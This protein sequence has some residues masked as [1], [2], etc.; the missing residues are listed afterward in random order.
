MKKGKRL[1]SFATALCLVF[2]SMP[3]MLVNAE[4]AADAQPATGTQLYVSPTG[5]DAAEG[6]IGAPLKTL[7]GA[8]NKVR[9]L[10]HSGLPAG[11]ITVNLLGGE[12]LAS[13]A[14]E[15][16]AA[17]SGEAG[18]P[19]VWKAAEGAEVTF[20]GTVSVEPNRFE[21]VTDGGILARLPEAAHDNVYVCDMKA[22]GLDN[23]GPIPK[24]GYGWPEL[25]PPL[26]VVMDGESMHMARYPDKD[27]V[28]PSHI[29][30]SGFNPR[31]NYSPDP[32]KEKGPIWACKDKGLVDMFE[33][34]K[35]EEDVWTYGYFNHTY[36][37]DNVASKTVEMDTQYGVKFTGKH[38]TWYA[39]EGNEPKKFYVYNILCGLDAP[40]EYYLDRTNDKM[41]V[42]SE[43]D[44]ASRKVEL[45]VLADP[46]F[47]LKGA[48]YITIEG[49]HFTAGNANA[50]DLY[51]SNHILIADCL[52][53]N[54]G[55]KGVTMNGSY[56]NHDNTVQSCDFKHMGSGGVL[57]DGGEI[58]SL[59]L[60]NNKVDNCL[61]DDYSVIKRTYAPAVGLFGCGNLVTRNKITNAPHQAVA[62]SGNNH[63]IAG[64]EISHVLYETGDSGAIYTCTR[65]WT[66]RGNVI[67]NN[68]FYD[69]P[70]T[71]HGGTYCIYLDDMASGT[72]ATNNLF[73][74][75]QAHAFLVGGGRDNVITN[76][77]DINNGGWFI[78][79][80]NRCMGWAHKS[81]HIPDGGNYK[82]WKTMFDELNKSENAASLAKWEAQ[83]PGMFDT[84]M[85]T[86]ETCS[87]CSAQRSKGCIPKNA[88]IENNIAVGGA[89]YSFVSEVTTY[90]EVENNKSY[91][92][93]TDI[94]FV[95][96]AGQ[97]FEVKAGSEIEKIQGDEHFKSSETGM[98]RDKYRTNLGVQV[99]APVLTDPANGV[100]DVEIASGTAFA[101]NPVEGADSYLLEVSKNQEFTDVVVN[102]TVGDPTFTATSLEKETTYYWRVTAF[103]GRL[104]GTSAVSPVFTFKTSATDTIT[105]Y[106]SFGDSSFAGWLK[107]AGTP[108]RTDKQAHAG[109]YSYIIDE[110]AETIGMDFS[111]PQK[112]V[113]S[114]W[115]YDTMS[116]Q[117]STVGVANVVPKEGSWGAIGVN[118]R[119]R[120]DK[121]VFR[122]GSTFMATNVSRTKGWHEFKWDYTSGTDC[123]MYIDGQLVHTIEGV[124][125]AIRMEI[126]DYWS[127]S[128]NPG[129]V[130]G[131]MFDEVKIGNPVINPV[132]QKLTLDK[133][134]LTLGVGGETQLNALL[135]AIPDVDMP[136]EWKADDHEVAIV[137]NGR[138]TGNRV[139]NTKI[140]VSVKDYPDVKAECTVHVR[141]DLVVPVESVEVNPTQKTVNLQDSFAISANVLPAE[142]TNKN[143]VWS[144]SDTNVAFVDNGR[145][146]TRNTGSAVITATSED[147]GKTA[148]CE[149]TVVDPAKLPNPGFEL[150]DKTGWS[151]YPGTEAEGIKW[152]VNE[153]AARNGKFGA[154]VTTTASIQVVNG[155]GYAHKG[156]QY[157]LENA[158]QSPL[159]L[160]VNYTMKAWV[161]AADDT[162]HEMGIF[163]I[164]RGGEYSANIVPTY[165]QVKQADGWVQLEI[166]LT[167]E[168]LE[169]Y[170]GMKKLD[171]IIGNKNTTESA[172]HFFVD[173][174][175]LTV[176]NQIAHTHDLVKTEEKAATC[177][178]DGNKAYWICNNCKK[179]FADE[180][181]TTETT[182]EQV[183]LKATG[184]TLTH[185]PAKEATCTADGNEEYWTCSQCKKLF[186]NETC[187]TETTLE[188]VTL[189]ATGHSFGDWTQ[190]KAPTCTEAG[191]ETRS[192][193]CG[194]I[195][196]R[197]VAALDHSFGEWTQTKAPT[198]TEAGEEERTCATCD[199]TET[200]EIPAL[201]HSF[202]DWTQTKAPTCTE[203]GEEA[204]SCATCGY[205]ET[206]EVAA[207]GHKLTHIPGKA[208][209]CT[210][211][212]NVAYWSCSQCEKLFADEKSTTVTTL[213]Q[214]TLKATGHHFGDW[215]QTKAPTCT[216]V[217]TETR[218]CACGVTEGRSILALG[219]S[220]G[221]WMQTKAPTCTEAG[222][223]TR[224]CAC[225]VTETR[226]VAVLAHKL[227]HISGKAATC[228]ADGNEEHWT[229]SQCKNRFA[230]EKGTT[231][232]TLERVTLKATGHH[233]GEWTQTKAPTCTEA[234]V[235]TRSCTCDVTETREAAALGH[236]LTHVPAKEATATSEGN[237]EYYVC[238]ECGK[239]YSD[240][241]GKN[242]L[243]KDSLVIEVLKPEKET[244]DPAQTGGNFPVVPV[245]AIIVLVG[246]AMPIGYIVKKRK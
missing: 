210:A 96:A 195:E 128:G 137:E 39:M 185:A 101:W 23:I 69:I 16:T 98:Y 2:G 30:D 67:T 10:K 234:G 154:D 168:Q 231:V 188:Q 156:V 6:T 173:D 100:Q 146:Y 56:E 107:K 22:L 149:V 53:T 115:M 25:P 132:P 204:R 194:E 109:R 160:D 223:Q 8:R 65:D 125:G 82:A 29:F 89:S 200:R 62:F 143:I 97:N 64:N 183:T 164:P 47:K 9:E 235:E 244:N 32:T 12:Y 155:R 117:A 102:T 77:I 219:H 144:S 36:A 214:V 72:I 80:D 222:V 189:K 81:A 218:S 233:F 88:V 159:R 225:G 38:P 202:G 126:G 26:N 58:L 5:D 17:D 147:G 54:M 129:D 192:C 61:F 209:T 28:K 161:K 116:K 178:E 197:E 131:F 191:E 78:R 207:L 133:T 245:V 4:G 182:L 11:G 162:T 157:R 79:Y 206:R 236:K 46:F 111:T 238:S 123:K 75:M 174:A 142:A 18:K 227:T 215:T 176:G 180:N 63:K 52:F 41:Y 190:T 20:S 145:V 35:Q 103:E 217:G 230:D 148:T 7:E 40:G 242:E 135:D 112:Q 158:D 179:L 34:L 15:L 229:C 118:V 84:D 166:S 136:L 171:F 139:G 165:K 186:A 205:T 71:T 1:L 92:A 108:T 211:D 31:Y 241:E 48:S 91:G 122:S 37:D 120:S 141:A 187:T 74:N 228:T 33:L 95:N 42:Y 85:S 27:F 170:T 196:T 239:Y 94:G 232:T 76:N 21:H 198:S 150:G 134:E 208:A 226:V 104:G 59:T 199:Y 110:A 13:S 220:F 240:A 138:V 153:G 51:D 19:I 130:C 224:S 113:F 14:L 68:Y 203:A 151:Q 114:V 246:I 83:Y 177:T 24:V 45:G 55:Q 140:T 216:E 90:G 163:V 169:K 213:E 87:Q 86:Q 221:G 99:Q 44:I 184:H 172:G 124:S 127:E 167:P 93:G 50:I 119:I 57:L 73:V 181:S 60:G 106:D 66:S 193:A 43:T 121:Y 201:D 212:G 3:T 243:E 105:L 70:N 152:S 237:I 175:E 49:L